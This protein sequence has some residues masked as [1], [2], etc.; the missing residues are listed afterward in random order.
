MCN[1]GHLWS[2]TVWIRGGGVGGY[3][4]HYH[5]FLPLTRFLSLNSL[6]LTVFLT[7]LAFCI[8]LTIGN[9]WL[10]SVATLPALKYISCVVIHHS[11]QPRVTDPLDLEEFTCETFPYFRSGLSVSLLNH[12]FLKQKC[13]SQGSESRIKH[14]GFKNRK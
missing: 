12:A 10:N 9:C 11:G 4:T 5:F 13:R 2:Y 3:A 14:R 7:E 1:A 8:Q 6:L